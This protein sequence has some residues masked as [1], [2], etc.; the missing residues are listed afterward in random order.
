MD[1]AMEKI[2]LAFDLVDED[3]ARTLIGLIEGIG[4]FIEPI[5][6]RR[7]QKVICVNDEFSQD[8]DW[9][10]RIQQFPKCGET[11]EI[12][13]IYKEGDVGGFLLAEIK[14]SLTQFND[15]A[16]ESAF[17]SKNFRLAPN[18]DEHRPLIF[19]WSEQTPEATP[20]FELAAH[21]A[22]QRGRIVLPIRLDN[23][24][25][26]W[27][28]IRAMFEYAF[29]PI[30]KP[31][32]D[33]WQSRGSGRI[34]AGSSNPDWGL[35]PRRSDGSARIGAGGGSDQSFDDGLK[36][37]QQR[38]AANAIRN[39]LSEWEQHQRRQS[40][41]Y[42][43]QAARAADE[44]TAAAV[45]TE[46]KGDEVDSSVFAPSSI[47]PG[48]RTLIQVFLHVP[49]DA[50]KA[51][52]MAQQ[53]N[54]ATALRQITRSLSHAIQ[55][56]AKIDIFLDADGLKIED[57]ISQSLIWNGR[58]ITADFI[59]S[60]PQRDCRN[61]Y[62][63]SVRIAVNGELIGRIAFTLACDLSASES[64]GR[65]TGTATAYRKAF[66]SY[67][68]EDRV[69]VL[70][71]AQSLR[72]AKI[73]IFQDVL[74]LQAGD[75]WREEI[76]RHIDDCDLFLLF[77]SRSAKDSEW[78]EKEVKYALAKQGAS[79]ARR[80]DIVPVVLDGPAAVPPPSWL[81]HLH[82]ND[83]ICYFIAGSENASV[84]T[85]PARA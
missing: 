79:P 9:R 75:R 47:A 23:L 10:R 37:I 73:E 27:P 61:E 76:E 35:T 40:T 7:G 43:L 17:N 24:S 55:R 78:V 56:R 25:D 2:I 49:G 15:G 6:F 8:P 66:L 11:Y 46:V 30:N 39:E 50:A 45:D 64:A 44:G 29:G 3:A 33:P 5:Y 21:A 26:R 63:P 62:F 48:S 12:R 72:L 36:A 83:P 18:H 67:S 42:A 60:A 59:V 57:P 31:T 71:R 81:S 85:P 69:E 19:V 28:A 58:P 70:K 1:V 68:S 84:T 4:H 82:F 32:P 80:P 34:G 38:L 51:K 77:W 41:M 22:T 74:T 53:A 13:E 54:L 65:C 16:F 14:N 52:E 20:V